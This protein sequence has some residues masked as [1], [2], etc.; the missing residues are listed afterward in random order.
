MAVS[1]LFFSFLSFF[2]LF[3][4]PV[5]SVQVSVC[6]HLICNACSASVRQACLPPLFRQVSSIA[7]SLK[8]PR[9]ANFA[10]ISSTAQTAQTA[11]SRNVKL[12]ADTG[13]L[14][15]RQCQL[16]PAR[17]KVRRGREEL[18]HCCRRGDLPLSST[19]M[20]S[21]FQGSSTQ[22]FVENLKQQQQQ[23]FCEKDSTEFLMS[24]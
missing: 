7:P 22:I 10:A 11:H 2:K 20:H 3:I 5:C 23:Q 21:G 6:N 17:V 18:Q 1:L 9:S 14:T 16:M 19:L 12:C 8:K 15:H 24:R 4:Q 13:R